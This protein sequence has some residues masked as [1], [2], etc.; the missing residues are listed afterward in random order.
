MVDWIG[1]FSFFPSIHVRIG[2]WIDIS[3]MTTKFGKQVDLEELTQLIKLVLVNSSREDHVTN[4]KNYIS[5]TRVLLATKHGRMVIY[6]DWFLP[7]N[8][9]EPLTAWPSKIM[10][11]DKTIISKLPQCL[12]SPNFVASWITSRVSY[13]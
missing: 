7:I 10:W 11:H 3:I 4:L 5:L 2:I 8:L 9:H 12:W 13:L 1:E 6:L